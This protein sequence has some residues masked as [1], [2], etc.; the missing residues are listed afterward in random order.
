VKNNDASSNGFSVIE[1]RT[2]ATSGSRQLVM[3][4]RV[5]TRS[6]SIGLEIAKRAVARDVLF[7]IVFKLTPTAGAVSATK[8]RLFSSSA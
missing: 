6:M 5:W 3:P 2:E 8:A 1:S 7:P 4:R